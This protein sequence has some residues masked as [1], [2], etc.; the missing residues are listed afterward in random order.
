MAKHEVEQVE[1]TTVVGYDP[2][3]FQWEIAHEE[4]PDQIV[5]D[6]IGDEYVGLY[7]GQETIEFAD[8]RSGEAKEFVQLRFRDPVGLRVINAGYD[9][10]QAF[11]KIAPGT[12]CRVVLMKLVDVGQNDP[13]KSYR[14]WTAPGNA[15]SSTS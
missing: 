4:S 8:K 1:P 3:A 9:L 12:M 5:F 13:M 14:V 6:T 7:L 2:N 11:A 10:L 15:D